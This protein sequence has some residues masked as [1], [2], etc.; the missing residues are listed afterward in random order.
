LTRSH[1]P[2]DHIARHGRLI[3]H[4]G[5]GR[6]IQQSRDRGSGCSTDR[7]RAFGGTGSAKHTVG[8]EVEIIALFQRGKEETSVGGDAGD[9]ANRN[10]A[11]RKD[12][13]LAGREEC[14]VD[15]DIVLR[16]TQSARDF[17]TN[18]VQNRTARG[19]GEIDGITGGDVEF[20]LVP[21]Q[22]QFFRTGRHRA[23]VRAS[24]GPS[25]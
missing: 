14:A 10:G 2:K 5:S 12:E 6:S 11:V 24:G 8:Q 4:Q 3:H 22:D 20:A 13:H 1:G 18:F 7:D 25:S 19:N 23:V 21:D 17:V 9:A 15:G 16:A